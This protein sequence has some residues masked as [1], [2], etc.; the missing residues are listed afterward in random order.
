MVGSRLA[1]MDLPV[2]GGPMSS[3]LWPPAA[4]ISNA[5]F[6]DSWPFDLGEIHVVIARLIEDAGHV[7]LGGRDFDFAFE[8]LRGLAE[9]L[10][11]DDLQA[12]HHRGFGGVLGRH[13]HADLAVGLR[14][15]GHRQHAFA[16]TAPRR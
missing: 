10:D 15:Q 9:I 14:A 4:A 12:L 7:H 2:P 8:K 6:T 1:S 16:R 11:G 3:T 5:R 13:E